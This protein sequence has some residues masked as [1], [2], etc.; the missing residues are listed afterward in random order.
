MVASGGLEIEHVE[1]V[2]VNWV[3]GSLEEWWETAQDTSRMLSLLLGGLSP[4]Q[5]EAL[6]ERSASLLR[7]YVAEDGSLTVPGVARV[8]VATA[9]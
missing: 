3:A 8:V 5:V 2:G 9:P 6:G 7:E 1:E 4:D